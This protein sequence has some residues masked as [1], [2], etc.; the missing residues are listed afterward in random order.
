MPNEITPTATV[1]VE[2]NGSYRYKDVAELV[3]KLGDKY[4]FKHDPELIFTKN[5]EGKLRFFR[6]NS[7]YIV[8]LSNGEFLH[9]NF[10]I[11]T[12]DGIW[13]KKGGKD[14]VEIEGKFYRKQYCIKVGDAH[15]L[16]TDKRV[17]KCYDGTYLLA[18]QATQLS[19]LYYGKDRYV[20]PIKTKIVKD[21][22]GEI[23]ISEDC[24]HL[25]DGESN[26][27]IYYHG[28]HK[29]AMVDARMNVFKEFNDKTNPQEDRITLS[30]AFTSDSKYFTKIDFTSGNGPVILVNNKSVEYVTLCI[31]DYIMPRLSAKME[32]MRAK[33][34]KIYSDLDESEN[35]AKSFKVINKNWG[36][37]VEIYRPMNYGDPLN[38][39]TFKKTGGLKYSFG[40]E[41]ETSQGLLPN[42]ILD[43]VNLFAVGDRSIGAAE[44]VTSPME[45]DRGVTALKEMCEELA[46][47]TLVDDRCGL[48]VHVGGLSE[49]KAPSFNRAFIMNAINLG[50]LIEEELYS[51]LPPSRVPTLYH[52]HS[53]RRFGNVDDKNFNLNVGAFVFG[54]KESWFN[55]KGEP[56][57]PFSFNKYKLNS[58][59]NTHSSLGA[60][61]E[62]RYKWLN[63][64]H[65]FTQSTH[66]TIE[67]RIFP[68]TTSFTKTYMYLM[69][70]LA[71]TYV[72]DRRPSIIKEGVKLKDLF[73]AAF[74][75]EVLVDEINSFYEARKKKFKRV[76]I[77]PAL[78]PYLTFLK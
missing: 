74:K 16:M 22:D 67:F 36:G 10:A 43:D 17:I 5:P 2:N 21:I 71:F 26:E 24:L 59:R 53:I 27:T 46:T 34:N 7:P 68:G 8:K 61:A 70:S 58:E 66:K 38:S 20:N 29:R 69:F 9:K 76:N 54:E 44:Y 42:E 11:L 12:E 56:K 64:I 15:Y 30:S 60:W 18:D 62:G 13:F 28:R 52:C 72:C 57:E 78:H 31:N 6:K 41:F 65:A 63:L 32:E 49:E 25:L 14:F 3:V 55:S 47:H 51:T 23:V 19:P 40:T 37:K 77:Y 45:G 50:A 4:F 48:H 35:T 33:I 1:I 73:K 39:R 75:D